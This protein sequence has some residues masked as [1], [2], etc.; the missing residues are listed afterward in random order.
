MTDWYVTIKGTNEAWDRYLREHP[1]EGIWIE[2]CRF[3]GKGGLASIVGVCETVR[4]IVFKLAIATHMVIEDYSVKTGKFGPF[5]PLYNLVDPYGRMET[6]VVSAFS[7]SDCPRKIF[8]A[9]AKAEHK[10]EYPHR[11]IPAEC[12][13]YWSN[14]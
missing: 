3:G 7:H 8:R 4:R 13:E 1:H 10:Q 14:N 11:D 12:T 5:R 9:R 2:Q 6:I